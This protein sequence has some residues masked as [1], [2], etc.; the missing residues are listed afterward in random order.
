MFEQTNRT[1]FG[2]VLT[3]RPS[4]LHYLTDTRVDAN[5][6]TR[7]AQVPT[8]QLHAPSPMLRLARTLDGGN[9][10]L[11]CL[12]ADD[13]RIG[14]AM[15]YLPGH[16]TMAMFDHGDARS[17]ELAEAAL[18]SGQMTVLLRDETSRL[19]VRARVTDLMRRVLTDCRSTPPA[20]FAQFVECTNGFAK[21]LEDPQTFVEMGLDP[22]SLQTITLS[23]CAPDIDADISVDIMH[24]ATK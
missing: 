15:A 3:V 13:A 16:F 21:L 22:R 11:G 18:T 24:A 14:A 12:S 19:P 9:I 10:R 1:P 23:V 4:T 17:K 20:S 7:T 6:E 2:A 5:G 8:L